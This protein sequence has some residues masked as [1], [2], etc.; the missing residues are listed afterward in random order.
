M[1][2]AHTSPTLPASRPAPA[3]PIAVDPKLAMDRNEFAAA[4]SSSLAISGMRLSWAGSKNCLTP[5]LTRSRTNSPASAICVDADDDRD[6]RHDDRLD[7]AG[8]T[9]DPPAVVAVDEHPREQ[10]DDEAGQ[11]GHHER[12]P[13]G[14]GGLGD[15][16]D[17]DAGGEVRQRRPRGRH[18]LG[19][20]QEREVATPEHREH[21][22]GR[23][24]HRGHRDLLGSAG[25]SLAARASR[26][27][28]SGACGPPRPRGSAGRGRGGRRRRA[29]AARPGRRR[30]P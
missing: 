6:E 8:R 26:G 4:S 7:Q 20:P 30:M 29:A 1:T 16:P 15:P 13:D 18:E 14:E 10:P 19:R 3:K 25:R 27:R 21:R 22:G 11:D 2:K 17:V 24:G 12:E 23:S 28:R 5:A 9:H